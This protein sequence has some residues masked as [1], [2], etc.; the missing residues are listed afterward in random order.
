MP[1]LNTA[2]KLYVGSAAVSAVYLRTTRV[3]PPFH[4]LYT[5]QQ[6]KTDY[7]AYQ[8]VKVQFVTYGDMFA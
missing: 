3:W 6:I 2:D 4:A 7:P 8:A 5:Y 1:V